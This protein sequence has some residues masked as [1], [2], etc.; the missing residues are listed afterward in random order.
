MSTAAP[1]PIVPGLAD[2]SAEIDGVILDLWGVVHNG[3]VPFAG[4]VDCM[5]RLRA[6][7]KPVVLLSNAPRPG[8]WVKPFLDRLGVPESAYD[9]VVASGDLVHAA[10]RDR[11]DPFHAVLGRRY[12]FWGKPPDLA[13]L[14]GLDYDRVADL[15]AADFIIA[16]GLN[17]DQRETVADY[18]D[19]LDRARARDL[20]LVCAN[21]DLEVMR[22][23]ERLPCAG[24]LA[25]AYE[26]R[27]GPVAWHGK[28][29][30]HAYDACLARMPGVARDRVLCIGDTPRTDILGAN[31]AGIRAI[32]V[33]G[34][35]HQADLTAPDGGPDPARAAALCA[36][37][38]AVAQGLMAELAW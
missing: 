36:G 37:A 3:V 2:L 18:G 26:A 19:R 34:G 31:R 23:P 29:E 4:A 13:M 27:G 38:G 15:D 32:L 6:L 30:R 28:P 7:G 21:P 14:D 16:A 1:P 20:P 10:L 5:R 12:L 35:L 25:Q 24:A 22:G 9:A 17:D 33:A 8:T 11:A